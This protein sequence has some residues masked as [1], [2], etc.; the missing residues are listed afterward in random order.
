[1]LSSQS[2]IPI[3]TL[4]SALSEESAEQPA[5]KRIPTTS[6][7][8]SAQDF[9]PAFINHLLA[10][11]SD[12]ATAYRA[13]ALQRLLSR[14]QGAAHQYVTVLGVDPRAPCKQIFATRPTRLC[15]VRLLG[16]APL[17]GPPIG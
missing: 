15:Y 14:I 12:R 1:M 7:K 16:C 17:G 6:A 9:L 10:N 4:F 13:R 5:E 8:I 3:V 11:G 2:V